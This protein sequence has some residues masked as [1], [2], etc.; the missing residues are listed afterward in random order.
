MTCGSQSLWS[1]SMHSSLG[2]LRLAV[3]EE[4]GVFLEKTVVPLARFAGWLQSNGMTSENETLYWKHN[5]GHSP[6]PSQT[7]SLVCLSE[8]KCVWLSKDGVWWANAGEKE[9]RGWWGKM[10]R[11]FCALAWSSCLPPWPVAPHSPASF[12]WACLS[13]HCHPHSLQ[14][15]S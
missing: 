2:K 5:A 3:F 9:T 10:E 8:G 7:S 12:D 11:S 14:D 6:Q 1:V 13:R 4:C 15:P